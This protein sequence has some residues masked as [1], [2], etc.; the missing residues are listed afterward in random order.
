M[1]HS[2]VGYGVFVMQAVK[3]GEF[4]VEYCG[5]L[6]DYETADAMADQT[7]VYYFNIK[8]KKYW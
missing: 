5:D 6:I 3:K 8:S 4:L 2:F 1:Y 7:Y